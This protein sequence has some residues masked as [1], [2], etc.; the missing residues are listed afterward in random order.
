MDLICNIFPCRS[1]DSL[2]G[3][4]LVL[5]LA[6]AVGIIAFTA[7]VLG[8]L[9]RFGRIIFFHVCASLV[10]PFLNVVLVLVC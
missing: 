3:S 7:W 9:M 4:P 10:G 8:P 5:Q 6:P 1:C 2:K